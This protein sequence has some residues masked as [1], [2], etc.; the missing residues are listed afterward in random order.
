M[1]KPLM[2]ATFRPVTY[3]NASILLCLGVTSSFAAA[4]PATTLQTLTFYS[5][6]YQNRQQN[7]TISHER[8]TKVQQ[9]D[10]INHYLPTIAGVSVGG[11]S[12]MDQN[13]YIRGL[14]ADDAG[15]GL[16]ITVDGV[17]QPETRGFHH[18]GV[19]S[20]DPELYK[21]TEVAVGN[22]GVTLGNNA[23]GGAVAFTT[24][25]AQDLLL[26]NQTVG[27]KLKLGYD[28]NDQQLH[29]TLTTYAKPN[30]Q[31]DVLLSYGE[32]HSDGG[33][34]GAG[35]HIQ[36]DDIKIKN[37]LLKANIM[38]S[39]GHKI[40]ASYQQHDNH[41]Q[42]PFRPNV[43]YQKNLPN[44]IQPGFLDNKTY[45]LG[46]QF[47]PNDDFTFETNVYHLTNEALSQGFRDKTRMQIETQGK[48]DGLHANIKQQI[49]QS[50]G[51][52]VLAHALQYGVEGYKKS[53]TLV[54]SNLTEDA[55]SLGVYLQD[56]MDFGRV[57]L[58][59]G[60][61]F[62]HYE[63][64]KRLNSSTYHEVTGAL[65]GEVKL[66]DDH[67]LFAS[68]TQLFNGPPL[69][70]TLHQNGQTLVND[71]VKAET[72]ANQEIGFSSQF[73]GIFDPKDKLGMTAKYF[74]TDYDNKLTRTTGI[75]CKTAKPLAG[76]KCAIYQ[77]AGETQVKGYEITSHYRLN[78]I[79]LNAGY[80]H[81]KSNT[82]QGYRLSKD[83]GNQLNFGFNY[84][85]SPQLSLG[86]NIR[87][88]ASL[89]RR[90]SSS[91][92]VQLPS[93]TTYDVFGS[94]R[95]SQLPQLSIDAG[96]YNV[97]DAYYAE[98]TSRSSDYAMG[99]N[100]KVAMNYQF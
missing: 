52:R 96:V 43:G 19:S 63:P 90:T 59:P 31:F 53:A 82:Q 45:A 100:I 30:D 76:G 86:S 3:L 92:A 74:N 33:K 11:T 75:D 23:I 17:R 61:R 28:S 95:P 68:Y 8:S 14:G 35:D 93:F 84:D 46:Y 39:A 79:R 77:N 51:N 24:V 87:H 34:D 56:R 7:P 58:T 73:H 38:P 54:S 40:T 69:P 83:A 41:G 2:T 62:D 5:N 13:I 37:T 57:V 80:A 55:T 1:L 9:A 29:S 18:A 49:K 22:N 36:G 91:A 89:N 60:V 67:T 44:N 12:G 64:S 88:V 48:T 6:A 65:A 26:P 42:Y 70:E 94:F 15:S 10:L 50:Y 20:L 47:S 25:D 97:T 81:A 85:L 98:H 99:R 66:S 71:S 21:S 32:R 72:G 16:K 4:T 27:A 78:D